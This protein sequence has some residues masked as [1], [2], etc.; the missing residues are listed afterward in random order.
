[1]SYAPVLVAIPGGIVARASEGHQQLSNLAL[2]L[3]A[4]WAGSSSTKST[5]QAS[6]PKANC[7]STHQAKVQS[8]EWLKVRCVDGR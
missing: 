2:V 7:A 6:T 1:M 4:K 5:T 3:T 8:S